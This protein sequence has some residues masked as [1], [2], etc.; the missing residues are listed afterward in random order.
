MSEGIQVPKLNNKKRLI[1]TIFCA[2]VSMSIIKS[3]PFLQHSGMPITYFIG[4]EERLETLL[5]EDKFFQ[6]TDWKMAPKNT[7]WDSIF[8]QMNL[9]V[10]VV[11][12]VVLLSVFT[13]Q[14]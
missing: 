3:V 13:G 8:H 6:L 10:T 4:G 5:S 2:M 1:I 11:F 14:I 7:F 9:V 12:G